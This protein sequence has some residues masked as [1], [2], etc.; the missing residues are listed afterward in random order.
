MVSKKK[1]KKGEDEPIKKSKG[2]GHKKGDGHKKD[3]DKTI[4][5]SK[6]EDVE[7]EGED[8]PKK[9]CR[10]R[11]CKGRRGHGRVKA[12]GRGRGGRHYNG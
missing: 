7:D 3:E 12:H 5:T 1:N 10:G 8:K 6:G 2:N 4:K 9:E 11:R